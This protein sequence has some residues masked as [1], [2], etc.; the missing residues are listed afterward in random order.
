M[1]SRR[2]R[3][4]L[5]PTKRDAAN[6]VNDEP[7][8]PRPQ[9]QYHTDQLENQMSRVL[10][11]RAELGTKHAPWSRLPRGSP[12]VRAEALDRS[13]PVLQMGHGPYAKT[14]AAIVDSLLFTIVL[15]HTPRAALHRSTRPSARTTP[16]PKRSSIDRQRARERRHALGGS[17]A[18]TR[19]PVHRRRAA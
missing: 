14:D 5:K 7:A 2:E 19:R 18:Y 15:G 1:M 4:A 8:V 10:K 16:F 13:Q 11:R 17:G 12:R 6:A 3:M 9:Q